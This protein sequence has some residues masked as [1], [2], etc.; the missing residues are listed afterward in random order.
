M[1]QWHCLC[2]WL[3][4]GKGRE[5]RWGRMVYATTIRYHNTRVHCWPCVS[6]MQLY[7]LPS[8]GYRIISLVVGGPCP[9]HRLTNRQNHNVPW[10]MKH[11]FVPRCLALQRSCHIV[12]GSPFTRGPT[13]ESTSTS[14]FILQSTT[15]HPPTES[16]AYTENKHDCVLPWR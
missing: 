15:I 5:K 1:R 13:A 7:R 2:T 14:I 4:P 9:Q 16:S 12:T 8:F 3:P 6:H 10:G 11:S